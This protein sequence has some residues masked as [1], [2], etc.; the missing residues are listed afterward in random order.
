MKK[1]SFIFV[2]LVFLISACTQK[3]N[4][5]TLNAKKIIEYHKK[6][7]DNLPLS[8]KIVNGVREIEVNAYQYGWEPENIVVKKGEKI[9]FMI[10][11]IDVPHGFELEGIIIPGWDVDK[12]INKGDK[13]ILEV[14]ADEAGAWD[15]VC[16]I[17]CG[18]GH[19]GMRGKYIVK[20][21]LS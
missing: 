5:D 3:E 12:S 10:T 7:F 14:N 19:I 15:L 11:S 6:K 8:G 21:Q 16:T 20:E 18:P 13:T 1:I 2:L 17:Y 4:Q 9:R